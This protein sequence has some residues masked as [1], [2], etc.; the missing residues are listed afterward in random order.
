[1]ST[2]NSLIEL[3]RFGL[4]NPSDCNPFSD[5]NW[6][7]VFK[8]AFQ[9]GVGAIV[10]D[11]IQCCYDK[12]IPIEI[13]TQAKLEWI[14]SVHQLEVEYQKQLDTIASLAKFYKKHGIR[15]MVLKGYGLSL[16]YPKPNHRPCSDLDISMGS[17]SLLTCLIQKIL[18]QS[19]RDSSNI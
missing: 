18:C 11:G 8:L 16:N 14:G 12:K 5:T 9:H 7:A 15:M 2:P 1:M 17:E 10:F 3:A 6:E 4:G 19:K 13:G